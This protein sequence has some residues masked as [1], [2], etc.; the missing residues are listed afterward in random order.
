MRDQRA[1]SSRADVK[2]RKPGE[3]SAAA[4]AITQPLA[5]H[6][7]DQPKLLSCSGNGTIAKCRLGLAVVGDRTG[8]GKV[9]ERT[10]WPA[11]ARPHKL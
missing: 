10:G 3:A 6:N 2:R 9:S 5:G 4:H 11:V 1:N 7:Q 8:A